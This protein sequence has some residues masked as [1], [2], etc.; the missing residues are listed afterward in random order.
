MFVRK[1]K[2]KLNLQFNL[3][4]CFWMHGDEEMAFDEGLKTTPKFETITRWMLTRVPTWSGYI[5]IYKR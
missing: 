5:K 3:G 4:V 2:I 1:E